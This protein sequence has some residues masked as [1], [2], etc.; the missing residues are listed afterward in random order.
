MPRKASGFGGAPWFACREVWAIVV[1]A[2]KLE[3]QIASILQSRV[4]GIPAL[5]VPNPVGNFGGL[6]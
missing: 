2:E 6:P 3:N 5:V 1:E 4:Q